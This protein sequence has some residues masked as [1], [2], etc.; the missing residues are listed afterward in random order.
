MTLMTKSAGSI[1][2]LVIFGSY[3]FLVLSLAAQKPAVSD[4]FGRQIVATDILF[5]IVSGLT[6]IGILL[7]VVPI[8][9]SAAYL[10]F[11]VYLAAFFFATLFSANISYSLVKSLS[12]AYLIGLAVLSFLLIEGERGLRMVIAAWL[13]GAMIPVAI[14]LFTILLYYY[15]PTHPFLPYV[16]YHF[17]A[18]PV[19]NFPRLS[20]T[21]VSA[22][23]SPVNGVFPPSIR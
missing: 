22:S 1:F 2:K 16:T 21:F 20:S 19:G 12:T 18:V 3:L 5:P 7:R 23:M 13:V 10:F 17:G 11:G 9:W 14:G 6:L 15:D 8:R 4:L